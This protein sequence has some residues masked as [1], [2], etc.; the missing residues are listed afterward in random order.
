[1]SDEKLDLILTVV[2]GIK[3]KID[4]LDTTA[5]KSEIKAEVETVSRH[6]DRLE[7]EILLNRTDIL[8][9]RKKSQTLKR[10][11]RGWKIISV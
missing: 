8:D 6:L 11:C 3:L 2:S 10:A 1:M 4:K 9:N 5:D 7:N